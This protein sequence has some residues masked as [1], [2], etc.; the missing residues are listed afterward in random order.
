MKSLITFACLFATAVPLMADDQATTADAKKADAK[1]VKTAEVMVQDL[2]LMVPETWTKAE[3]T[4]RM[5][6]ATYKT[7]TVEGDK[8]KG[9]LTIFSF[10][11]GGG[12]LAQNLERWIGQFSSEGRK[13]TVT[14]GTAGDN[15]YYIADV[16]GTFN[17]S[18]GGPF[19]GQ[20]E[21][22][23]GS[24]M[25]AAIVVLEGKGVYYLKLVG[26]EASIEAQAKLFRQS[27]GGDKSTEKPYAM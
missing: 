21:A 11:G 19:S 13:S 24:K 18:I 15:Q 22:V 4:S 17:K 2:K 26:P 12:G 25:L 27:F 3:N 5:R 10:P 6:L 14:Q 23:K 9:E 20:K 8:E 1:A 7:P 16:T